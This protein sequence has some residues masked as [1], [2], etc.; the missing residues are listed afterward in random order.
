MKFTKKIALKMSVL[1]DKFAPS[2]GRGNAK[3]EANTFNHPRK[4]QVVRSGKK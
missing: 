4:D 1:K 2:R 3:S